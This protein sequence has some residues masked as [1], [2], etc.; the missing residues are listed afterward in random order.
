[1]SNGITYCSVFPED[2]VFGEIIYS[3]KFRSTS[4][5]IANPEFEPEDMLKTVIHALASSES[6]EIPL[7]VVL[8]LPVWDDTP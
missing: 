5:C 3:F 2:T 7:L 8:V 6:I 1:M 4:S